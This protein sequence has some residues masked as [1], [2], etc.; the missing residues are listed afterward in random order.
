LPYQIPDYIVHRGAIALFFM[1]G[2][3]MSFQALFWK[4]VGADV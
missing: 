4:E 3:R 2:I 1:F